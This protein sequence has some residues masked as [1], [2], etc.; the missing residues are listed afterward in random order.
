VINE[1]ASILGPA[2]AAFAGLPFAAH[3]PESKRVWYI[4]ML[5]EFFEAQMQLVA[6][7]SDQLKRLGWLLHATG[8]TSSREGLTLPNST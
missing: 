8:N 2:G 6:S 5:S 3:A 7:F 1:T 4:A